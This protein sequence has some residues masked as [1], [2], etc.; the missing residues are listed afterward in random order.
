M[1]YDSIYICDICDEVIDV[2]DTYECNSCGSIVGEEC[3]DT[4]KELCHLCS[5]EEEL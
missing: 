5:Q 3:F 2:D 1:S 4:D